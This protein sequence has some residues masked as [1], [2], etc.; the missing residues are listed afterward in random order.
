MGM[1]LESYL[2]KNN[3][4]FKFIQ[5]PGTIHTADAAKVTGIDLKRITKNLICKTSEG[6]YAILIIPGDKRVNLKEAAEILKT[7]NIYL[8]PFDKAEEISGYPPGGTPS[9]GHKTRM[10]AIIDKSILVYETVYCGGGTRDEILEL[11]TEDIL[12]L[13]D[14]TI[15]EIVH[16]P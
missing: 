11:R 10:R 6:E 5:K 8:V 7:Q 3:V 4:W 16:R 12:K 13:N 2:K 9:V 1:N 14:A 15:G